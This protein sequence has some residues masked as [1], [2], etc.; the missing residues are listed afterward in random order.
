MTIYLWSKSSEGEVRE[1]LKW[2][3]RSL[4]FADAT[5]EFEHLPVEEGER[6]VPAPG[7]VIVAMGTAAL[8]VL[9]QKGALPKNRSIKSLRLK[10]VRLNPDEGS[11]LVSYDPL[12]LDRDPMVEP[13]IFWDLRLA[14]RLHETGSLEA[15]I[16]KYRW[17]EHFG[18]LIEQINDQYDLTG[19]PVDVAFDTE[20]MGFNPYR[21]KTH[22]IVCLQFSAQEGTADCLY[23]R[24]KRDP[25][26]AGLI[27]EHVRWLLN[28][29]KVKLRGA[30]LKFDLIWIAEH[31]GIECTNF[32]MDT[33]LA[34]SL[35]WENRSNSLN[36][37]AKLY[38]EMG[39]YDDGFNSKFDKSKMEAVPKAAL[40]PYAGGDA[41]A[42]LRVSTPL[43][44]ELLQAHGGRLAR[45]YTTILH[46]AVRAFERIERRGVL[47]DLK[48]YERLRQELEIEIGEQTKKVLNLMP[49]RLRAKHAD[50]LNLKPSLLQ[51][52]F[53]GPLG[54]NLE[55]Q[56]LTAK[57]QEPSTAKA[58]LQMF[59]DH[60]EAGPIVAALAAK[61]S[62]EKMLSTYVVGF[63]KHLQPDGRFH[64]TYYLGHMG[65]EDDD[66]DDSGTVSGRLSCKDPALQTIPKKGKWAKLLRKCFVAPP[67]YVVLQIDFSQGE[68]R[69]VAC[70]ANEKNMIE[71]YR[72]GID[73]HSLTA[74][75]LNNLTVEQFA[76]LKDTDKTKY[77]D[78][79]TRAKAGNFGLLYGMQSPGFVAY[80]WAN[81]QIKL[82][83]D[84]AQGF[85]HRFLNELYP[86][87]TGYHNASIETVR[88]QAFVISPLGRARHLPLVHSK[89]WSIK[90][91]AERQAIN[92]VSDDTEILTVDG[93]KAVDQL[94]VGDLAYTVSPAS[95]H[96]EP[97]P[98]EHLHVGEVSGRMF[99][100]EHKAVSAIATPNH[101]WLIDFNGSPKLKSS[102]QLT[103]HGH[104]KIWVACEGLPGE[105]TRWSDDEV[106][107]MGWVLTDGAYRKQRSPK[108]GK[109]WGRGRVTVTQTKPQ[110]LDEIATL[111]QRLGPH[112]HHV[113]SRGQH[114][115]SIS[116]PAGLRLWVAMPDKTLTPKVLSDL[117]AKQ[118]RLLYETMLKGDGCWDSEA[119]RYRKFCAGSK[120][121]A[122]A[123]L[124]L[125]AMIGQPARS[126]ERDFTAYEARQYESM[127]NVPKAGRCWMVELVKNKRAQPQHGSRWIEWSGRVWCPT[128]KHGT[129]IAKRNGKVFVTGNS[130][131]QSTL[132]DMMLWVIAILNERYPD[133]QMNLMCHDSLGMYVPVNEVELWIER[134]R[135]VAENLPFKQAFGWEPQ[136]SFPV[137]AG[138]GDTL[139]DA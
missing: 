87:L 91:R 131:I 31:L 57:T 53:F 52:L 104:D 37:H 82:D 38:S 4:I 59:R 63:L 10:Q 122:E 106:R 42:T 88:Q 134:V 127:S 110:N 12:M 23:I 56:M 137:D 21:P 125:C 64:G 123:F 16:G 107:L 102:E 32:A 117:S 28:S 9:Q 70:V 2:V 85:R 118:R 115:W 139:A 11:F 30:N 119:G 109:I 22:A 54:M 34:G 47:A 75:T 71:A 39:G 66:D 100:I 17:V 18:E 78:M 83:L 96:M 46:P 95:G 24:E 25:D 103:M 84:F 93:W 33:T 41:D 77:D 76:K 90:S 113:S 81:F 111:F 89:D 40:L 79:R 105:D 129:W 133:L 73:L 13:D 68:L 80:A 55:P 112:A 14:K 74:S 7:D 43:R 128:L 19:R 72:K 15:S 124:M 69:V 6:P 35:V 50:D 3:L 136:L 138:Y 26:L 60:P 1:C 92:C 101:R 20:T 29:P 67:G 121:R 126:V 135:E 44:K 94:Q 5:L 130:P 132:T 51:E 99:E 61:G 108:T 45:F 120:E 27:I 65:R 36:V 48:A 116:H 86:G 97:A 62:A 8:S 58:H 98:I 49:R 114:H